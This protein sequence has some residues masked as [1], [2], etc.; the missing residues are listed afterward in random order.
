MG[1][2]RGTGRLRLVEV[3]AFGLL[4]AVLAAAGLLYLREELRGGPWRT[5]VLVAR[6]EAPG[7]LPAV[8]AFMP[9]S[10]PDTTTLAPGDRLVRA[11]ARELAGAWPW[12][13]YAA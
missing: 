9:G 3:V 8:V 7:A 5:P 13:V 6:P 1:S 12:Q 2:S 4:I 10:G 11:G